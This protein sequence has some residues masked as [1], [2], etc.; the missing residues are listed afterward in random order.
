[1]RRRAFM[2]GL[3][4]TVAYPLPVSAQ[5]STLP[6]IGFLRSTGPASLENYVMAFRQ[7]LEEAGFV[8]GKN[9]LVEYRYADNQF[10]RLPA[11]ADEERC[12]SSSRQEAIRSQPASSPASIG[13]AAT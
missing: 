6:V 7:G 10:D 13:P 5:Q 8:E 2:A 11:L 12:R 1:M 9:V 3:G 4:C